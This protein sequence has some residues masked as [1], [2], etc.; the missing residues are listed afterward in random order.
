MERKLLPGITVFTPTYNRAH[1]LRRLYASLLE[2]AG[3]FEWLVVD[4]GST[5]DTGVLV[6]SFEAEGKIP[7]RYVYKENGGKH[8]AL[9]EG[10]CQAGREYFLCLDS[11]DAMAPGAMEKLTAC[12]RH[13]GSRGIIA[14]KSLMDSDERIGPAFP[15][16]LD[17]CTLFDLIN[18]HGCAGDRTLVYPTEILRE[19]LIPEPKGVKFFPET[20]LYDRFDEAHG[21]VLLPEVICRCEYQ[22]GGYSDSF[23]MLMIRNALS[24]KWFYGARIDMNSSFSV[25]F[26]NLYRYVAYSLLAPGKTGKYRGKHRY[27]LP[28]AW[29]KGL[30]MYAVYG[31]YRFRDRKKRSCK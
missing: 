17:V 14:Y 12:I 22:Q 20:Y 15:E 3:G 2:Q 28:L 4:D 9:N 11:D 1:T 16:G 30:V 27:L 24:M 6:A 23:R 8:T 26:G 18:V 25:R 5:D 13:A 7:I 29:P 19:N 10:I 21:S 31:Y